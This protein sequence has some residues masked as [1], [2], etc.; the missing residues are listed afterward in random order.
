MKL[1]ATLVLALSFVLA[2]CGEKSSGDAKPAGTGTGAAAA[3]AKAT[4]TAAATAAPAGTGG[5]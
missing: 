3:T 4:G 2:G 5:W 1:A